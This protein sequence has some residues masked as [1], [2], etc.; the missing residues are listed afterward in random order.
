MRGNRGWDGI[1][2]EGKGM[3]GRALSINIV[4]QL[5]DSRHNRFNHPRV[6]ANSATAMIM[7]RPYI[8]SI[9]N[10]KSSNT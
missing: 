1:G 9:G 6:L 10:T 4:L 2:F 7:H 3:I 5:G 8:R